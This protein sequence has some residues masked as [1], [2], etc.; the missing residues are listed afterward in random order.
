MDSI[1]ALQ[2]CEDLFKLVGRGP[3]EDPDALR[4][5]L[6]IVRTLKR[7]ATPYA[8]EKL[9]GIEEA[10]TRWFSARWHSDLDGDVEGQHVRHIL[11]SYIAAVRNSW[12][13]PPARDT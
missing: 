6:A 13:P 10:F 3:G 5:A 9:A 8:S 4:K 1:E 11:L 2:H 12:N 7:S